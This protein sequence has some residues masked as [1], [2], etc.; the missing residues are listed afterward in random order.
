MGQLSKRTVLLWREK[1]KKERAQSNQAGHDQD[2]AIQQPREPGSANSRVF[3]VS[4]W[5]NVCPVLAARCQPSGIVNSL[6]HGSGGRR[7]R[8]TSST[9]STAGLRNSLFDLR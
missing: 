7:N 3:W 8:S 6:Y 9:V 5:I 4:S 2:K 1:R